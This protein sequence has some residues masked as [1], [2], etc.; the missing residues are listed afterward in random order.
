MYLGY[1]NL[2]IKRDLVLFQVGSI[3]YLEE[4]KIGRPRFKA[5]ASLRTVKNQKSSWVDLAGS[6]SCTRGE[7]NREQR[8][9]LFHKWTWDSWCFTDIS[10]GLLNFFTCAIFFEVKPSETVWWYHFQ[11]LH[12]LLFV[13]NFFTAVWTTFLTF[14]GHFSLLCSA[15]CEMCG[16]VGVRDAFYSKTKRFCSVSCSRSYSSNSKKASI[17]ARLQ[18]AVQTLFSLHPFCRLWCCNWVFVHVAACFEISFLGLRVFFV[19][20]Q[21]RCVCPLIWNVNQIISQACL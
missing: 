15:T 3:Q 20:L 10:V 11:D 16:M 1:T 12:S 6:F 17:L 8:D 5:D 18:V 4:I 13:L 19:E 9:A 14:W 7:M 2:W 21:N